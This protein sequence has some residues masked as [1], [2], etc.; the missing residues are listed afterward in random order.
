M[1]QEQTAINMVRAG[2]CHQID[3]LLRAT[4]QLQP[5]HLF[6]EIEE[7]RVISARYGLE[8]LRRLARGLEKQLAEGHQKHVFE[9]WLHMMREAASC[10][11]ID[12]QAAETFIAA[13]ALRLNS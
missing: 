8:P 10:H 2:L 3:L 7:I 6:N 11:R 9:P 4:G 1:Q 13:T 5:A 12:E